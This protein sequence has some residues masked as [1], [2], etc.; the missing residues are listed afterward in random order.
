[1]DLKSENF[2]DWLP[3]RIYENGG[4]LFADWIFLGRKR[5]TEPFHDST[6]EIRMREP[7]NLLFQRQMPLEF[8]DEL[9]EKSPGIAPDGFIFHISRCGSTLVSQMFAAL[10]KNI[11][12][13][14]ASVV[15]RIIRAGVSEELK[16][17]RLRGLFNALAQ[18]R[19]PAEENFF[20]KFDS[21]SIFDLP[22]IEKAFPGVPWIFMYRNPVEV[23]VSQMR[24][25]G[26]Q[27]VPGEIGA[28]FPNMDLHEILQ[29]ST[30]ERFARTIAAFCEAGLENAVSRQG[31]FINY[32]QLPEAVTGE[33]CGHFNV[34][35]SDEEIEKMN[36]A[37]RLN[38]KNPHQQFFTDGEEKRKEANEKIVY[39]SDKFVTPLYEKLENIRLQKTDAA[40]N[41]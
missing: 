29:F 7:F 30:E 6:L 4:G 12:I 40:S 15:D 32:T 36:S 28:I 8:L 19:F 10:E 5:F 37:S 1:M 41:L 35:F 33:I 18:K 24:Q 26:M 3:V 21:W 22:L 20:V 13:S 11:V 2:R 34:S 16:I 31:K 9:S 23:I 17:I 25:S 27:M 39:F 38:A 14:E